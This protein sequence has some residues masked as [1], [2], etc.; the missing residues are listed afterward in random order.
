[1]LSQLVFLMFGRFSVLGCVEKRRLTEVPANVAVSIFWM[2][3]SDTCWGPYVGL[4][5]GSVLEADGSIGHHFVYH[6]WKLQRLLKCREI[7]IPLR[8]LTLTAELVLGRLSSAF[9]SSR[10]LYM[11]KHFSHF[12]SFRRRI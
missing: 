9:L 4:A 10:H 2:N 7:F 11:M 5:L 12:P 8:G 3:G 1:M 6:L